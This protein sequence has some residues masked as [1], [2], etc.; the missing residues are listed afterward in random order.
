M[1]T[2]SK[3]EEGASGCDAAG[4]KQAVEE[5]E[6][7]ASL[8][9]I[10]NKLI[11]L[12]GKGGVGKSTVAVN[13][14][15]TLAAE[16]KMVGLMDV[17]IHG[18]SVPKMLGLE[19]ERPGGDVSG[20]IYPVEYSENLKVISIGFML[21]SQDDAI[22][23]RGPLKMGAIKQFVKDVDWGNLDYLIVD[24]PPGTGDEPLSVCQIVKPDGAIVVTTPQD[25]ALVDVKK[26]ITFC[27]NL[28]VRVI[29]VVENMSGFVCP[30]CGT[31][32]DIFKKG[33]GERMSREMKVPFLG[34]V[35]IEVAIMENG[36]KG[37][38]FMSLDHSAGNQS[39][40]AFREI[41]NN[42]LKDNKGEC[43]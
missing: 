19:K 21:R 9:K 41:V 30:N 13:L 7:E 14:A 42:I 16:G 36:D 22:I 28:N 35:P 5:Q 27:R 18:P 29:G 4:M 39:R 31:R 15:A 6:I 34:A 25:V 10:K 43:L 38:P 33:G 12:S 32:V 20:R 2:K 37:K 11:V 24:S 26:S 40:T 23:W 17:D 8:R 3:D 1:F